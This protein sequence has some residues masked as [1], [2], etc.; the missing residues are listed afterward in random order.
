MA[1]A[2]CE[3]GHAYPSVAPELVPVLMD[4]CW[5]IFSS[6]CSVLWPLFVLFLLAIVL[7]VLLLA[8]VL[9]VLLLLAIVLSVLL[10]AIVLSVLRYKDSD[11]PCGIYT[12][13]LLSNNSY[14]F[15]GSQDDWQDD[16][17][18][19]KWVSSSDESTESELEEEEETLI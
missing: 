8:I 3:T 2:I 14:I 9:S 5:S 10:L 13:F 4:S 17:D 6:L 7:S 12:F 18:S 1:G 11:Y 19:D 15:V 16:I